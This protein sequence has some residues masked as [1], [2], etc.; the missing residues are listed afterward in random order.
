MHDGIPRDLLESYDRIL[1][2]VHLSWPRREVA[3]YEDVRL[4]DIV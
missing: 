3:R 4:E 1:R 2:L